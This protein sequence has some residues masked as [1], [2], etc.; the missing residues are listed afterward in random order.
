MADASKGLLDQ[1]KPWRSD[2]KWQVVAVEAIVLL[3]LGAF[4]LVSTDRA[5]EWMLQIIG[6][7]LLVVSLQAAWDSIRGEINRLAAMESFRAGVGVTI[8]VIATSLWWSDYVSTDA[9]RYIL[10]W[11]LIVYAAL[12]ILAL[13]MPEG[14]AE[15]G[16]ST[17]VL[18]VLT[19]ILG[20]LLLTSDEAA[21]EDRLRF[22]GVV[23]LAFGV[24]LG[25]LAYLIRSQS[26]QPSR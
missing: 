18:S 15:M 24:L 8:G 13:A 12:Q 23:L 21:A 10:G 16:L 2:V 22:L 9:V 6:L 4:M 19:L 5:G 17:L 7:V 11:G 3:A 25:A 20:I 1:G 14:R 26:T